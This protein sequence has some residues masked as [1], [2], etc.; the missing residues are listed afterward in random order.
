[1]EN[2]LI[3]I[4][5][6]IYEIRG[7]R[8]MI[9]S[10]LARLYEVE[11]K[12][13]NRTVSRNIK[14]FPEDFMFQLTKEEWENLK[15]QF[16]ISN[17]NSKDVVPNWHHLEKLKYRPTLPY[18][19]TEQGIA[20]LSGL[21]NSDVAIN[22]NI[23]IMRAFVKMRQYVISQSTVDNKID[24]LRKMLLLHIDNTENKFSEHDKT[25]NQIIQALNNFIEQPKKTRQIGFTA[26]DDNG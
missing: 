7:Q 24:D 15:S 5:N 9:D 21:L 23:N 17:E 4:Q 10:D 22:V 2:D 20:M 14:R 1:M 26:K 19:F 12:M 8:V 3:P 13:L 11:T 16:A 18:A 6:I 25:I